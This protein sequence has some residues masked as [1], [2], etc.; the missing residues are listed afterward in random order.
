MK[1]LL[2]IAWSF[3][4]LSLLCVGGGWSAI[5]EMQRQAISV[6]GWLTPREFV[7]GL[8]ISQL[9]PGPA[10][11]VVT[12]IGYRAGGLAGAL[13]ATAAMFL[14]TCLL[15]WGLAHWWARWRTKP[16]VLAAERALA[17]LSVG[18][19]AAGVYTVGRAAV[20]D[21]RTAFF[22]AAAAVIIARRWLPPVVV[23]LAAG[24]AGW[25]LAA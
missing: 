17:P 8:A 7:D 13:V 11:L 5:P 18:L 6:H 1:T 19:M 4:R 2:F 14:P 23:F 20:T 21:V 12:F 10:M 22:A 25:G 16:W 3:F 15:T 24:A 9:T